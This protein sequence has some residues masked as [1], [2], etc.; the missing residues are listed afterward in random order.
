[1]HCNFS[2]PPSAILS[3]MDHRLCPVAKKQKV[4]GHSRLAW[5]RLLK[6]IQVSEAN[7]IRAPSSSTAEASLNQEGPP[8]PPPPAPAEPAG[9]YERL[10]EAGGYL[11]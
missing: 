1:M 2:S 10:A 11:A 9:S 4:D 7:E 8:L 6:V 5:E 3:K